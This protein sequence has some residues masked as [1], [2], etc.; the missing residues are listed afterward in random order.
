MTKPVRQACGIRSMAL[1]M[2]AFVAA[3]TSLCTLGFRR[4]VLRAPGSSPTILS[5]GPMKP[6]RPLKSI[7]ALLSPEHDVAAGALS[8]SRASPP[9]SSNGAARP[10]LPAPTR[11]WRIRRSKPSPADLAFALNEYRSKGVAWLLFAA[12]AH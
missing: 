3:Y 1:V 10:S 7:L 11:A 6:T 9:D 2:L 4:D 12:R 8:G 5:R